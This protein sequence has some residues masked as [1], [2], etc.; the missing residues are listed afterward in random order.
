MDICDL[1]NNLVR[2]GSIAK[3]NLVWGSNIEKKLMAAAVVSQIN[4]ESKGL[5]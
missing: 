3:I 1:E 2:T 5:T 4:L